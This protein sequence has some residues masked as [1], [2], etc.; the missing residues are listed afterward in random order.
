MQTEGAIYKRLH[1][2]SVSHFPLFLGGSDV[3]SRFCR[4]LSHK[5]ASWFGLKLRPHSHYWL[6]LDDIGCYLAS[7]TT[8][9]ELVETMPVAGA[10][11][12]A[13]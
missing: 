5:F 11:Q 10:L 1:E 3:H 8:T 6:I 12:L 2:A 9:K 7:F 4:T 13:R